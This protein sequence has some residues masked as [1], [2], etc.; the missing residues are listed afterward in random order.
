MVEM[1]RRLRR[2]PPPEGEDSEESGTRTTLKK[3]SGVEKDADHDPVVGRKADPEPA[4]PAVAPGADHP[5]I[6]RIPSSVGSGEQ[7]EA[8]GVD[9]LPSV[10]ELANRL[11]PEV[12]TVLDELFRAKWTE[13]R[14]LRPEDLQS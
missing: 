13:V 5:A 3:A 8:G 9:Q 14:R 7:P 11:P 4:W 12:R 1:D 2:A 10:E 6:A